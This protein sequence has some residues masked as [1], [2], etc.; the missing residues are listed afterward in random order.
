VTIGVYQDQDPPELEI[1]EPED[2]T[3]W[4]QD[5][6]TV[7]I[8][9]DDDAVLWLNG[10]RLTVTG[11]VTMNILL[12]EGENLISVKAMDPAG[13]IATETVTVIRDTEPPSLLVTTPAAMEVW[14]NAA[15]LEVE[16]I[17]LKATSVKAGGQAAD[18]D[19]ATGIFTVTVPLSVGRNNVTV[20]ASDGVNVVSQT[21]TVWV[22]RDPPLLIVNAMEPV[23]KTPSVTITG[24]TEAGIDVV[25]L[26]VGGSL[27]EYTVDYTGEFAVT[28]NLIDGTYD[29]K[30]IAI[31]EY[32]NVAEGLTGAF[33]VK[34]KDYLPDGEEETGPS[35]EPLHIGLILAV[36]GIAL[37]VAA[38]ASAH[39][40]TKRRREEFEEDY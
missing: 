6:I 35:V 2:G 10:R 23:I 30:V 19:E 18:F 40:I 13:N 15:S 14:T 17:A 34:A 12:L 31:D 29:I 1:R 4:D 9:A 37:L 7:H 26:E 3:P 5:L 11:D 38:Y 28:L 20:E 27:T 25:T 22:N 21:I 33:T 24:E 36:I 32:G 39:Y 16:G 8:V